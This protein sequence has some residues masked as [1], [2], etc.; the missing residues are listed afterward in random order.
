MMQSIKACFGLL[1]MYL[2]LV[3]TTTEGILLAI[4]F[5][6][7]ILLLIV[8]KRMKHLW[9]WIAQ[10]LLEIGSIAYALVCLGRAFAA[11]SVAGIY[12][13]FPAI[14]ICIILGAVSLYAFF[15]RQTNA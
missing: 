2:E 4:A 3:F 8:A 5:A 15:T 6:A 9:L 14:V 11:D 12:V 1:E 13:G 7:V 10:W